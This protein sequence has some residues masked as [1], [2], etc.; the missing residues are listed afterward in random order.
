[1]PGTVLDQIALGDPKITEAMARDAA[2]LARMDDAILAL[3]AGYATEC[4]EGMFSQGEWQL[5]P[6]A[7]AAAANPAVLLLDEITANL[8]AQTEARVLAALRRAAEGRTVLSISHRV[9]GNEGTR[10]VV[11]GSAE[12][13]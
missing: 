5:L 3:S 7:R 2:K 8:D 4:A 12:E 10:R 9:Y 13:K 11:I 6:I 1:M